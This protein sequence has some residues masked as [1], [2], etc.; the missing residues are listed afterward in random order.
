MVKNAF[1]SL[2][3]PP[4][5]AKYEFPMEMFLAGHDLSP[6]E[7]NLDRIV[8]GLTQWKPATKAI[9]V[10][11][12]TLTVEGK[13][14]QE[15]VTHMNLLFLRNLWSDGLPLL[16]ATEESVQWMLRGTALSPDTVVGKSCREAAS[17]R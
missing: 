11:P 10:E 3:F 16:P 6:I 4:A 1:A 15:A 5:A 2:G 17:R 7:Q 13:D 14:Y 12:P 8:E 9:R